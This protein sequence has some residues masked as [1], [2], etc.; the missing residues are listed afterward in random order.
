MGVR[1]EL[2]SGDLK[3]YGPDGRPFATYLELLAQRD[4]LSR[5]RVERLEAR[6]KAFEG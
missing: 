5:L 2:G 1:F 6:L 4:D 3:L